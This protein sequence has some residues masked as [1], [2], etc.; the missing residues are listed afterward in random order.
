MK[1]LLVCSKDVSSIV[2]PRFN[3]SADANTM[4]AAALTTRI[5]IAFVKQGYKKFSSHGDGSD[6]MGG[7]S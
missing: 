5:C 2:R 3:H 1:V 4:S 6:T 7:P